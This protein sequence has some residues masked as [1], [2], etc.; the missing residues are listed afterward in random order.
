VLLN[1]TTERAVFDTWW[2]LSNKLP[3]HMK[4]TR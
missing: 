2:A 1:V 4:L 3:T